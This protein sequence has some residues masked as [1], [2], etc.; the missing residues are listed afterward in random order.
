V[1]EVDRELVQGIYD[2]GVQASQTALS[3]WLS[4]EHDAGHLNC[5]DVDFAAEMFLSMIVGHD[6]LRALHQRPPRQPDGEI[7]VHV[8][9][10]V[11][12]CLRIWAPG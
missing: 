10:V 4:A 6:I 12:A 2:C 7:A 8:E 1:P 9:K 5:P 11:K 3:Q